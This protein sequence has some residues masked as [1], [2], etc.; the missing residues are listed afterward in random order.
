MWLSKK[1]RQGTERETA[2]ELGVTTISGDSAAVMT[3]GEVRQLPVFGPLGLSWKPRNGDMVLV[4]QGGTG[5]QESCVAGAEQKN[6]PDGLE[7]GEL[8]L[9]TEEA[10]IWVRKNGR[11][12]IWGDLYINGVQY[13]PFVLG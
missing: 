9:H 13:K 4:I 7:P 6:V 3:R 12:E 5:G 10:S 2:A 1:L 8:C 11:V